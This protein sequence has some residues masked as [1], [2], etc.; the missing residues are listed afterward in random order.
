MNTN[1]KKIV[2]CVGLCLSNSID[3]FQMCNTYCFSCFIKD[4]EVAHFVIIAGE[5]IKE[6]VV[7]HGK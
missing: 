6:P 3:Q 7:Q 4:P 5:P 2:A 1:A